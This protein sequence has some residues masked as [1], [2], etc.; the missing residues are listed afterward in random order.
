MTFIVLNVGSSSLKF[1]VFEP[2]C[3]AMRELAR[4]Q[5]ARASALDRPG[6]PSAADRDL[7]AGILGDVERAHGAVDAVGHRVVHGGRAFFAPVLIDDATLAAIEALAPLAPL[8][9]PHNTMAIRA[10][11]ALRPGMAQVACFDTAFHRTQP[12]IHRRLPLPERFFEAGIE[13]YGFHGL[14][15]SWLTQQLARL[16]G[17]LPKRL[18]AFHLG[19]GASACAMRDGLSVNTSMGFSTLDGLMMGTRPG[20]LDPGVLLHLLEQHVDHDQL[21]DLL[22]MR[23]G[24]RGVSGVTADMKTLLASSDPASRRAVDMFCHHAAATAAGLTAALGGLD[25]I[26]FTGGIGEHA[27]EIRA[28]IGAT[29]GFLGAAID[30]GRN[31]A[32]EGRISPDGAKVECWVVAANEERVVAEALAALTSRPAT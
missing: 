25:A 7:V 2:S 21:V 30:P 4:G 9:Q 14:S 13:R 27:P 5:A 3:G 16:R 28:R 19:A 26:V 6:A 11:A 23:S 31:D 10:V 8:H 12:E 24:L 1:A 15:Y 29:L 17:A 20:A 22:Y 18:L 32:R